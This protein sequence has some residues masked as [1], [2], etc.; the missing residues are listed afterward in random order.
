MV[1][2]YAIFVI[3]VFD[4]AEDFSEYSSFKDSQVTGNG[5]SNPSFGRIAI[6]SPV[7]PYRRV[8]SPGIVFF[9]CNIRIPTDPRIV[10]RLWL[11][12]VRTAITRPLY[13]PMK[14]SYMYWHAYVASSRLQSISYPDPKFIYLKL[15]LY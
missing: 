1:E 11:I 5:N 4:R 14:L 15:S 7:I 9:T 13:F 3:F 8:L 12:S 2:S 10:S 6:L